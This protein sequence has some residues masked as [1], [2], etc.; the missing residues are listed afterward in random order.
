MIAQVFDAVARFFLQRRPFVPFTIEFDAGAV[1]RV[2][3]PDALRLRGVLAQLVL[4]ENRYPSSTLRR[5][6]G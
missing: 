1:E 3:H 4:P 5:S 6:P 2:T